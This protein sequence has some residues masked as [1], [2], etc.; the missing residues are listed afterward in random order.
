MP[1]NDDAPDQTP[2]EP[3]SVADHDLGKSRLLS[4]QCDTCI[5]RPGNPMH[6]ATGQ[7]NKIT[8]EARRDGAFAVCHDTLP[9]GKHPDARPA[10]CRGF[11]D[12][13]STTSLQLMQRLW[14]FAEV[15][16]P[17]DDGDPP[18]RISAALP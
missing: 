6:L 2:D 4:R 14:G 12:R 5:Y 8:T 18:R 11:H 16:P 13:Y 3:V 15:D 1:S 9:Y 17:G 7:L 10:I